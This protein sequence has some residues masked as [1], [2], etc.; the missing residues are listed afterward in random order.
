MGKSKGKGADPIKRNRTLRRNLVNIQLDWE[1]VLEDRELGRIPDRLQGSETPISNSRLKIDTQHFAVY[2]ASF[3]SVN[4]DGVQHGVYSVL[5][6]N[7]KFPVH[8]NQHED[9]I[10]GGVI[11]ELLAARD[12]I[13]MCPE[14]ESLTIVSR[15]QQVV[16]LLNG[17]PVTKKRVQQ[18]VLPPLLKTI[19]EKIKSRKAVTMSVLLKEDDDVWIKLLIQ[20]ANK[21][22]S[23]LRKHTVEERESG[24]SQQDTTK[25]VPAAAATVPLSSSSSFN[26][27]NGFVPLETQTEPNSLTPFTSTKHLHAEPVTPSVVISRSQVT[28]STSPS[29]STTGK[30]DNALMSSKQQGK[31]PIDKNVQVLPTR[32]SQLASSPGVQKEASSSSS[33]QHNGGGHGSGDA[34]SR[35]I[36]MSSSALSSKRDTTGQ[37]IYALT[38]AP[39]QFDGTFMRKRSND[40]VN[41]SKTQEPEYKKQRCYDSEPQENEFHDAIDYNDQDSHQIQG[42]S[43]SGSSWVPSIFQ[44][45]RYNHHR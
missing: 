40:E 27:A 21:L 24:S 3:D 28:G 9:P 17:V 7:K 25:S 16:H 32:F 35:N 42:K 4:E 2:G 26:E 10:V 8:Y 19:Q 41:Y 33:M 23:L 14:D 34:S 36:H 20:M 37:T 29:P 13:N 31:G 44:S 1:E 12:I 30:M 18:Y 5:W 11:F 15:N 39:Q 45:R 22:A 43:T 6:G 38:H